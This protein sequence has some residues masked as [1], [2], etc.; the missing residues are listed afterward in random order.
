MGTMPLRRRWAWQLAWEPCMPHGGTQVLQGAYYLVAGSNALNQTLIL[1]TVFY[2]QALR[3]LLHTALGLC[4]VCADT[5]DTALGKCRISLFVGD[6]LALYKSSGEYLGEVSSPVC[7]PAPLSGYRTRVSCKPAG[8]RD[9]RAIRGRGALWGIRSEHDC[10]RIQLHRHDVAG[11][12]PL[13]DMSK[14][15]HCACDAKQGKHA[16][17]P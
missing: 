7:S 14:A 8:Q 13:Q 2:R 10:P 1:T 3:Q 17:M 11:T 4:R 5:W 16:L 12:R 15:C 6:S 9:Q